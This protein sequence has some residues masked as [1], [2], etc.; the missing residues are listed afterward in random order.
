M[1]AARP[2]TQANRDHRLPT[3]AK[4]PRALIT[5]PEI[6][7]RPGNPPRRVRGGDDRVRR[8]LQFLAIHANVAIASLAKPRANASPGPDAVPSTC[9]CTCTRTRTCTRTCTSDHHLLRPQSQPDYDR[10]WSDRDFPQQRLV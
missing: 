4:A 8:R 1:C 6:A 2:K 10:G 3:L 5:Q 9:T 7:F